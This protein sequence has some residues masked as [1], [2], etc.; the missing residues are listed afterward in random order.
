MNDFM[1]PISAEAGRSDN[2]EGVPSLSLTRLPMAEDKRHGREDGFIHGTCR[3]SSIGNGDSWDERNS[4]QP[5]W[6]AL[7]NEWIHEYQ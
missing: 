7:E 2:D 1:P 5:R 3:T 6:S 4:N